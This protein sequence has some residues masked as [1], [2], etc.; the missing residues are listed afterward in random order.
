MLADVC[1]RQKQM[2]HPDVSADRLAFLSCHHEDHVT[3]QPEAA[4]AV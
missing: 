4:S 3:W 2:L 1:C